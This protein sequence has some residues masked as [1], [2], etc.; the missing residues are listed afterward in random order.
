[1]PWYYNDEL[2]NDLSPKFNTSY[3]WDVAP[4][5]IRMILDLLKPKPKATVLD[6]GC[7]QGRHLLELAKRD[8]VVTGLDRNQFFFGLRPEE[9]K[10]I[11]CRS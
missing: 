7:G 11:K 9:V 5:E 10:R 4:E 6:L 2:W 8:L 1:M 3:H